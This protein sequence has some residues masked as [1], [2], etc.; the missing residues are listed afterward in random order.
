MIK[1]RCSSCEGKIG[2]PEDFSGKMVRCPRCHR[3]TRVPQVSPVSIPD[4]IAPASADAAPDNIWDDQ[5]FPD[6][7]SEENQPASDTDPTDADDQPRCPHC[8][9]PIKPQDRYCHS[10]RGKLTAPKPAVVSRTGRAAADPSAGGSM[11]RLAIA[12]IAGFVAALAGAALWAG[13][14]CAIDR[15]L[16]IVAWGLG[17]LIGIVVV[18]VTQS[19]S[20]GTRALAVLMAIL[21]IL[22]GKFFIA[23]WLVM[24]IM[25]KEMKKLNLEKGIQ[26]KLQELTAG[27]QVDPQDAK[28]LT[29]DEIRMMVNDPDILFDAVCH[30]FKRAHAWDEDFAEQLVSFHSGNLKPPASDRP[31]FEDSDKK[32]AEKIAGLDNQQKR[33]AVLFRHA[34]MTGYTEQLAGELNQ[35]MTDVMTNKN[36]G[37]FIA[38]IAAFSLFDILWIFLAIA[39]AYKIAAHG[40]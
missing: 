26:E 39:S 31:R 22:M 32:V 37:L 4:E 36:I 9:A 19:N 35:L 2:V 24:P 25:Q 5:T 11:K 30:Q 21:C 40:S 28:P 38:F 1:F 29:E 7:E 20:G 17:A 14:A 18:A 16:G 34:E 10:C 27:R 33:L 6:V 8:R 15:E 3:P 12:G 13:I 23:K